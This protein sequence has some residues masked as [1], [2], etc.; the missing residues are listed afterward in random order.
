MSQISQNVSSNAQ[1]TN[2][3]S[4]QTAP[5]YINEGIGGVGTSNPTEYKSSGYARV[6]ALN[7]GYGELYILNST[8]DIRLV[9]NHFDSQAGSLRD[10]IQIVQ[11]LQ[12]GSKKNILSN[13]GSFLKFLLVIG[14]ILA[15]IQAFRIHKKRKQD[16]ERVRLTNM[17]EMSA[18][19]SY[20]GKHAANISMVDL[21]L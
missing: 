14:I 9:Y 21:V 6:L 1:V 13:I 10:S 4:N 5:L 7:P 11:T 12:S 18:S 20:N 8:E 2:E 15:A 19:R 17:K 16:P 3:T